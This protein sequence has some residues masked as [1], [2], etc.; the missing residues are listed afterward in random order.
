MPPGV[1]NI[2][3]ASRERTPEVVDVWLDDARVR[4]ITLH[5]LDA[6]RQAPGARARPTR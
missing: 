3:T 2:V 1:L 6:G 5:R 4:K